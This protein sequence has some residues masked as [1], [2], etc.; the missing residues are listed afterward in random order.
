[1]GKAIKISFLQKKPAF[2]AK[3]IHGSAKIINE[4]LIKKLP[5]DKFKNSRSHHNN[6]S[7]QVY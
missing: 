1:M 4:A 5:E 7:G 2:P 6:L 3:N